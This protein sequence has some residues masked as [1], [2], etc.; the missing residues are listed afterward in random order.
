[1]KLGLLDFIFKKRKIYFYNN[2]PILTAGEKT[3]IV[4]AIVE[5]GGPACHILVGQYSSL[6]IASF[7]RLLPIT[8]IT[9]Q[10]PILNTNF[11]IQMPVQEQ[12][13]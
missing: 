6:P 2:I 13:D 11:W 8:T 1:M 10:Q 3:Y 7:S 12:T 9:V 4:D 5:I